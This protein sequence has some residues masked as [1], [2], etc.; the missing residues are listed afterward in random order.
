MSGA[1]TKVQDSHFLHNT[2]PGKTTPQS[3]KNTNHECDKS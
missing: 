2:N 1:C 3:T